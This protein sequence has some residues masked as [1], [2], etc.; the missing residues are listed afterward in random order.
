MV[1]FFR[2][3]ANEDRR[4]VTTDEAVGSGA[5]TNSKN[6]AKG[7]SGPRAYSSA[8]QRSEQ[9]SLVDFVP[10]KISKLL[11]TMFLG[12]AI[13]AGLVAIHATRVLLIDG[14]RL[15]ALDLAADGNLA[16]WF[17]SL[18]LLQAGVVAMV[19]YSVRRHRLDDY[20]GS[21][22]VWLWAAC[23]FFWLSIDEG[24][25]L[26][27]SV[28]LVCVHFASQKAQHVELAWLCVY[29]L[30]LGGIAIRLAFEMR[31]SR[32]STTIFGLAV[33]AGVASVAARMNWLPLPD[34]E[35]RVMIEEGAQMASGLLLLLAMCVHTRY[36]V[37]DAEGLI[38]AKA[39]KPEA[40]GA[41]RGFFGR[42]ARVDSAHAPARGAKRSDLDAADEEDES[43]DAGEEGDD[44]EDLSGPHDVS[45]LSKSERKQLRRQQRRARLG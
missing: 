28:Q 11:L 38:P 12:V 41:R 6:A 2:S 32:F 26:N 37:H 36:V 18:L 34:A 23:G 3:S 20:Q 30:V 7:R 24:A 29:A 27:E 8:A 45:R 19:I 42:K 33:A 35:L 4:R 39:K 5:S 10:Q 21:Y 14:A 13:A 43:A 44:E 15:P 25:S 1:Q 16:N 40:A 31:S 9:P 22:R 17:T